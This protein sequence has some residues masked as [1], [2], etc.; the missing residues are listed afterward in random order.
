MA[1]LAGLAA[2]Y[3][4]A[5]E[6]R[7]ATGGSLSLLQR[8]ELAALDV[9]I[10]ARGPRE[11]ARWGVAI[12]A[13][14]EESLERFGPMPW[15][16]GRHA[17]L[18]LRL[19]ELGAAAVAFDMTFERPSEDGAALLAAALR[20]Y[21]EA[22]PGALEA[23]DR[24]VAAPDPD[25]QLAL[26]LEASGRAVLGVVALSADEALSIGGG[27]ARLGAGLE[28]VVPSLITTLTEDGD[29]HSRVRPAAGGFESGA[30]FRYFGAAVPTATLARAAGRFGALNAMPDPDGVNRSLPV[31]LGFDG[32]DVLLPTL[33]VEAVSVARNEPVE[34]LGD[35]RDP[36]AHA[37]RVGG[38]ALPLMLGGRLMLD[39]YGPFADRS[40]PRFSVAALLDGRVPATEVEGRIV[41]VAATAIGTHDQRVT[42][43]ERAVP[44]V[45][46]HATLAQNLLD[47]RTLAR[48]PWVIGLELLVIAVIAVVTGGLA[49]LGVVLRLGLGLALVLGWLLLDQLVL[50]AG[51]LVVHTLLPSLQLLVSVF[52]L[53]LI[54][55]LSEKRERQRTRSAF[56]R[57]LSPRVM[58]RVLSD[59]DRHLRLG[60]QRHEATVLF[61]DIRGFTSISERLDPETLG[62]LLNR[63]MT[64]MTREVF[65]EEGTLDK[66]MGDAVMAFWGAPIPQSDHALRACRAAMAMIGRLDGLN[67]GFEAEGLPRV[68]I[69]I[70]LSTGEMTIGNM[71][72][73]DFF[74]YTAIGD[75]VNLGARLEG[76]TKNYGVSIIVSEA[77]YRAVEDQ[78]ACRELDLLR[79]KGKK[80][81][82]RIYELIGPWSRCQDRRLFIETFEAGLGAFRDRR[83]DEA[84]ALFE[85][86]SA[87]AGE[88]PCSLQ[89]AAQ[90]ARFAMDPPP[91]DWDG[92]REA[93]SK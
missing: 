75:R 16:R 74:A 5:G 43:L 51:G 46:I 15:P 77:T 55:F 78:M 32:Q 84:Q 38:R 44:G 52:A 18:L 82:E 36:A 68:A 53:T 69:G 11:P 60:G 89:Y 8:L 20:P 93:H 28:A 29:G 22:V 57:Y 1:A 65:G 12:A 2:L 21:L 37:V 30:Y 31:V 80:R 61:S 66:Y 17:D 88:D 4:V 76:Q 19:S 70:G 35:P 24:L 59:P 67:Q 87:L 56:A 33:A 83:F 10:A 54:G 90:C 34:L 81:P 23:L 48:P 85:E 27:R 3:H 50:F 73:D 40:L 72:S 39:W 64:P 91:D 7:A 6:L 47:G 42:P 13:A 62:R 92:V 71:G 14:D 79:V 86:A 45:Y 9:K 63:Y 58:E 25:A 41:F 49:R 26:G